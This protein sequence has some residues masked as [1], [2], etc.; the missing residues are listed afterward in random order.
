M[1]LGPGPGLPAVLPSHVS[2]LLCPTAGPV[3]V[4]CVGRVP[5]GAAAAGQQGCGVLMVPCPLQGSLLTEEARFVFRWNCPGGGEG[6][7]VLMSYSCGGTAWW[8]IARVCF[9]LASAV[10]RLR[11]IPR[12]CPRCAQRYVYVGVT[13]VLVYGLQDRE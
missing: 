7:Q 5:A 1:G 6:S 13:H 12:K 9:Y 4:A 11:F 10:S 2:A 3:L 8:R